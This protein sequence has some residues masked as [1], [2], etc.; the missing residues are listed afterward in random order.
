MRMRL[1]ASVILCV[2]DG[3]ALGLGFCVFGLAFF[4]FLAAMQL[5]YLIRKSL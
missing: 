3:W 5:D 2:F 1:C 4:C